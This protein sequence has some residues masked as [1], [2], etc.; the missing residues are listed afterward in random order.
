MINENEIFHVIIIGYGSSG[1]DGG[2]EFEKTESN[3]NYLI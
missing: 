3:L 1:I 2:I